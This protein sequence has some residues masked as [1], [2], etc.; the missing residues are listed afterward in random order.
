[1]RSAAPGGLPGKRRVAPGE[2]GVRRAVEAVASNAVT[3]VELIRNRVEI[4][5]LGHRRVEGGVE[6]RH[7]RG[8]VAE[9]RPGGPDAVQVR[10]VVQRSEVDAV[11]DLADDAGVD[12]GVGPEALA[13]VHDAV[14]DR[15][16]LARGIDHPGIVSGAHEPAHHPFDRR[17][18]VADRLRELPHLPPARL[19]RAQRLSADALDEPA[20]EPGLGRG[21]HE[22][23][24]E[25]RGAAV[26]DEHVHCGASRRYVVDRG[27]GTNRVAASFD[28]SPGSGE[29]ARTGR[30]RSDC[31]DSTGMVRQGTILP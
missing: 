13:A 20:R 11:L 5:C 8:A 1:M 31:P 19:V 12:P 7:H 29:D 18:V 22:Q 9:R 4:R 21:V 17:A 15:V 25:R 3:A 27:G 26:E 24:L 16:D 14:T 6:Y 23:E 10:R 28:V 30:G 2:V